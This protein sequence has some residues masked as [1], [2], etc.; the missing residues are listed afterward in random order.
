MN[1]TDIT[2]DLITQVYFFRKSP[3]TEEI[4][5]VCEKAS[6]NELKSLFDGF[7]SWDDIFELA[8]VLSLESKQRFTIKD[9]EL[10]CDNQL[11]IDFQPMFFFIFRVFN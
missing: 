2:Y 11:I 4:V 10:F 6:I 5:S 1:I 3:K 8:T 9:K 7:K